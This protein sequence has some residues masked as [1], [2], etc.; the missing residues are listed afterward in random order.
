[1]TDDPRAIEPAL[2]LVPHVSYQSRREFVEELAYRHWIQRGK[3]L[4]SPEIDWSSAE[5]VLCCSLVAAGMITPPDSRQNLGKKMY[6][7]T[8]ETY[9]RRG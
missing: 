1:M 7:R 5:Q 6:R 4:G 9:R 3:P 2:E 8:V